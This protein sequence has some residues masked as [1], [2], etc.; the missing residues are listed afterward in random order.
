MRVIDSTIANAATTTAAA[1][2][3]AAAAADGVDR[4]GV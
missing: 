2:Y 3:A 4:G 1:A